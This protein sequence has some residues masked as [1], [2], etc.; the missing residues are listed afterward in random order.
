MR[1]VRQVPLGVPPV[2]ATAPF[3]M[4]VL[5]MA[6]ERCGKIRKEK[7]YGLDLVSCSVRR[8]RSQE[9]TNGN[10]VDKSVCVHA[11]FRSKTHPKP[12]FKS[13]F[14]G[15]PGSVAHRHLAFDIMLP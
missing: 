2:C 13:E 15:L 1:V 14:I 7:E 4:P 12:C 9:V 10:I 3:C 8:L 6:F 11:P 5:D